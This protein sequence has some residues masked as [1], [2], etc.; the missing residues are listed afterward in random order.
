MRQYGNAFTLFY[1]LFTTHLL[2]F[3]SPGLFCPQKSMTSKNLFSPQV[4]EIGFAIVRV[5]TGFFIFRYGR[6]LFNIDDLLKFLSDVK[7]PFP[8]FAGYAAKII[9][10][11]GGIALMLG[12]GVRWITIPLI[13]VMCGVIYL[14]AHG[15]IFEGE[16]CFLFIL[17]FAAFFFKG[18]GK[19]SL[20]HWIRSRKAAK[21]Q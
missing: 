13:C 7:F 10:L 5:F 14:T 20:D 6:E 9:E 21:L 18:G 11:V 1:S 12:L 16:L 2:S 17:L 15:N 3:I 8:V 19:W 4:E